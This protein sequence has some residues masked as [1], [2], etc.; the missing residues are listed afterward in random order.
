MTEDP[1]PETPLD[2]AAH[3]PTGPAPEVQGV[4]IVLPIDLKLALG[5]VG[6]AVL[7][8]GVFL[9]FVRLP[10]DGSVNY[11][12]TGCA[13]GA[14]LLL[15]A[16]GS[17]VAVAARRFWALWLT[18]PSAAAWIG[19]TLVRSLREV[20]RLADGGAARRG[21]GPISALETAIDAVVRGS[22]EA[23]QLQWGWPVLFIGAL[24]VLAAAEIAT[25]CLALPGGRPLA[26]G[27]CV[28]ETSGDA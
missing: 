23:L 9:P 17:S 15:L 18:G 13:S 21:G 10:G 20:S 1:S 28:A 22:S 7:F 12:W 16:L 24:L 25:Y 6:S 26:A 19:Y 14:L 5:Y 3:P 8:L 2:T 27:G 11:F 4:Q